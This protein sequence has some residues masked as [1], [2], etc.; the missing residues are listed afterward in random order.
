[1]I[2]NYNIVYCCSRIFLR[3][4]QGHYLWITDEL[5]PEK[6]KKAAVAKKYTPRYLLTVIIKLLEWIKNEKF[7][8]CCGVNQSASHFLFKV[9]AVE[10]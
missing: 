3:M 8:Q 4:V 5:L 10:K 9:A 2:L 7:L 1:M 6:L